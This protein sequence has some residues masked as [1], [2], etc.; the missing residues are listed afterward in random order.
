MAGK[1]IKFTVSLE[2]VAY[3]RW[4]AKTILFEAT[5]DDAARH[6][7][8]KQLEL[9]RRAHRKDDPELGLPSE[10]SAPPPKQ[11]DR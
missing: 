9:E 4:F 3:L 7:M 11:G 8:M 6:L 5:E 2:A 10:S 1:Q